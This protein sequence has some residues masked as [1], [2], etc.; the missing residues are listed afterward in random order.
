M[1]RVKAATP[2]KGRSS[3]PG[4]NSS[5]QGNNYTQDLKDRGLTVPNGLKEVYDIN[6]SGGGPIVRDK[7]WFYASG[8]WQSNQTYIAGIYENLNAGDPTAWTYAPDLNRQGVYD[9]DQPGGNGRVTWQATPKNKISV[10]LRAT[11]AGIG[12]T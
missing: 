12:S 6:A 4:V 10:L 1:C 8:R 9:I 11:R 3:A 2:T 5:F 7:L